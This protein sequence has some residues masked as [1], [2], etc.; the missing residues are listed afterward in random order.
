MVYYEGD[1]HSGSSKGPCGWRHFHQ[2]VAGTGLVSRALASM[3]VSMW[4]WRDHSWRSV[5]PWTPDLNPPVNIRNSHREKSYTVYYGCTV[6]PAK[7]IS[8]EVLTL[9]T[10]KCG[11]IWKRVFLDDVIG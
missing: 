5:G 3:S 6:S 9:G 11:L 2:K 10:C 7:G 1:P 8:V 4:G